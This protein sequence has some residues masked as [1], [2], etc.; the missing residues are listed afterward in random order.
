MRQFNIK[1][2]KMVRRIPATSMPIE[3]NKKQHYINAMPSD[4]SLHLRRQ[5]LANLADAQKLAVQEEDNL[6]VAGKW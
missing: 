5:Q 3:D 4:V 2:N 6:I 1:F